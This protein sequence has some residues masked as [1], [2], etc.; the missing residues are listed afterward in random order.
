MK[1]LI[2]YLCF[3]ICFC[4]CEQSYEE[5]QRAIDEMYNNVPDDCETGITEDGEPYILC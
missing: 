3:A 2:L 4:V 1:K 5:K